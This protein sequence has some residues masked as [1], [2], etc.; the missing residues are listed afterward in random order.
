MKTQDFTHVYRCFTSWGLTF[1][2]SLLDSVFLSLDSNLLFASEYISKFLFIGRWWSQGMNA[3]CYEDHWLFH[4]RKG[5]NSILVKGVLWD[6]P[7]KLWYQ[8]LLDLVSIYRSN[9]SFLYMLFIK[10]FIFK[11]ILRKKKATSISHMGFWIF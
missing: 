6:F 11:K 8:L 7:S 9:D 1:S 3:S 5:Q 2:L 4:V 10:Q